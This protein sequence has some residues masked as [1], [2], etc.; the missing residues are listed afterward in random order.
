M[1]QS[2]E[3]GVGIFEA[4]RL[5]SG[6]PR[7]PDAKDMQTLRDVLVRDPEAAGPEWLSFGQPVGGTA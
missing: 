4:L 1:R 5:H 6:L 2:H 3:D 7:Q